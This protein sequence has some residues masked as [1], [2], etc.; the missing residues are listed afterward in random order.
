MTK[1]YQM[2]GATGQMFGEILFTLL[3]KFFMYSKHY[4]V[5]FFVL[6]KQYSLKHVQNAKKL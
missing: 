4:S 3:E 5:E 6:V 2:E 1:H